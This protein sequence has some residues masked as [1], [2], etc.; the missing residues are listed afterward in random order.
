MNGVLRGALRNCG[1]LAWLSLLFASACD[2]PGSGP[3]QLGGEA[4]AFAAASLEGDTLRLAELQGVPVLLNLWATWCTPCR[5]ETPFLQAI[6]EEYRP[7][8][9][10]VVGVTVDGAGSGRQIR[11][12]LDEFG[13]TYDIL[14][15]P[16]MESMDIFSV[17]GLPATYLLD[18]DG[19]IRFIRMGPIEEGDP[20]FM[21]ALEEVIST[22]E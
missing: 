10:K 16:R 9:L 18:R 15:D 22:G 12:F 13:V 14:H 21:T 2:D 3:P 4:P 11:G 1:R 5:T 8:G 19:R 20:D 17:W 7:R 6:H